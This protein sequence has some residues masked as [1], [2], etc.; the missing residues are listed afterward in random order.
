MLHRHEWQMRA[1]HPTDLSR[2]QPSRVDDV[3][4]FER[5]PIGH[6]G[7]RASTRRMQ[8]DNAGLTVDLG[9]LKACGLGKGVSGP[10]GIEMT[11]TRIVNRS[12]NIGDIHDGT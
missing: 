1:D 11:F 10:V 7:P 3:L 4:S 8:F 12:Q 5:T 6:D 2:P 9:T